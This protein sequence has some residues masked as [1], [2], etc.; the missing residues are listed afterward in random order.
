ML[1]DHDHK[2]IQADLYTMK[3]QFK[4]WT[5]FFVLGIVLIVTSIIAAII[6]MAGKSAQDGLLGIYLLMGLV[7]I[8][9]LMII[10]RLLVWKFGNKIV[11]KVQL[12]LLLFVVFLW[13]IKLILF[14]VF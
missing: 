14:M 6:L 1:A 12:W 7:P 9:V 13:I 3:K 8:G 10:D 4:N 5:L 11:N 2:Y